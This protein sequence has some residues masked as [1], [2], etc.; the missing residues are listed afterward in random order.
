MLKHYKHLKHNNEILL[1]DTVRE[2]S[3][4]KHGCL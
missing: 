1:K 2:I 3:I 4:K